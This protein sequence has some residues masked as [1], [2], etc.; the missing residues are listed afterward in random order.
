MNDRTSRF[1]IFC[2]A[3][4]GALSN[5][6]WRQI[7]DLLCPLPNFL[8][9]IANGAGQRFGALITAR[10][11][12]TTVSCSFGPELTATWTWVFWTVGCAT[13]VP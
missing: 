13:N 10:D 11:A 7:Y 3:F 8:N 1:K 4:N 9:P 2:S 5:V 6:P 12:D